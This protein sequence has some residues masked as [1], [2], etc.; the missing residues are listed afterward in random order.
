LAENE[1]FGII[2]TMVT[3]TCNPKGNEFVHVNGI[4]YR[5]VDAIEM[6]NG[7]IFIPITKSDI[8]KSEKL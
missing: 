2:L 6:G 5:T 8:Q 4:K 1:I 7:S 3:S